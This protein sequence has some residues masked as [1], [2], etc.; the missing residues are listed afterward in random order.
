MLII[1]LAKNAQLKHYTA[2]QVKT[3][4][5]VSQQYHDTFVLF[6]IIILESSTSGS[7]ELPLAID[8]A[9]LGSKAEARVDSVTLT[10]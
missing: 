3:I 4:N 6:I 1:K 10:D 8:A 9:R 7:A 2:V 5:S